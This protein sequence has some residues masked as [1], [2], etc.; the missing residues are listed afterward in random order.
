[1]ALTKRD[2]EKILTHVGDRRVPETLIKSELLRDIQAAWDFYQNFK[3]DDAK[4]DNTKRS[5]YAKKIVK[6]ASDLFFL[7][8]DPGPEAQQVRSFM[9]KRLSNTALLQTILK[10]ERTA[11]RASRKFGEGSSLRATLA[12]TPTFWF[13]GHSL[14][15][16]YENHFLTKATRTRLEG[17][18]SGPF[19]R[20]ATGVTAA[21]G[22]PFV[23]ETVTKA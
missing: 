22:E 20:F 10:L 2:I 4:G 23:D 6:V 13:L 15:R 7:L 11:S 1:M 12:I 8:N 3:R 17:Q 18:P 9:G 21:L 16:V 5:L 14:V 19:I